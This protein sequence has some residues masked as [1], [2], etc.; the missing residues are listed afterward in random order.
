MTRAPDQ[1]SRRALVAALLATVAVLL[2]GLAGWA[3][4]DRARSAAGGALGPVLRVLGGGD[5]D[6]VTALETERDALAERLRAAELAAADRGELD[7]LLAAPTTA[8]AEFVPAHVVAVGRMGAGGPERVTLD[9]G[10]RDGISVDTTVVAA[11]G[12]VGRVV[13]V[14]PWT[15]DVALLGAPDVVVGVRVG[16]AGRIGTIT[17]SGAGSVTSPDVLRLELVEQGEVAVGD[18]VRTLGS[19]DG[20]PFVAGVELG[21]VVAVDPLGGRATTTASVSPSVDLGRLGVVAVLQ[22]PPRVEPRPA[23]TGGAP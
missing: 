19:V 11:G 1:R 15:C 17:P 20:R 8:G 22:G 14:A 3:G 21:R 2:L 12:L 6:R 7:A 18:L 4:V 10:A 5:D 23:A 16:E 9:V 13:S